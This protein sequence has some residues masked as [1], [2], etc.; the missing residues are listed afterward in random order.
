MARSTSRRRPRRKL[1]DRKVVKAIQRYRKSQFREDGGVSNFLFGDYSCPYGCGRVRNWMAIDHKKMHAARGDKPFAN[2]AEKRE[3]AESTPAA[4]S[5]VSGR[6]SRTKTAARARRG[7]P[8]PTP[9]ERTSQPVITTFLKGARTAF[10]KWADYAPAE[11]DD[12]QIDMVDLIQTLKG[13][14]TALDMKVTNLR[15]AGWPREALAPLDELSNV[16]GGGT[17]QAAKA[18]QTFAAAYLRAEEQR[19]KGA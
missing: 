8:T 12:V 13:F 11:P 5:P 6:P 15:D 7:A 14:S 10:M 2:V 1:Q 19:A 9:K 3:R 18:Y 17:A 16:I 4:R